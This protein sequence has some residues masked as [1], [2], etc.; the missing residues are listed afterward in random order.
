[1]NGKRLFRY[2]MILASRPREGIRELLGDP[3]GLSY[4]SALLLV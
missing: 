4:A 3:I 2:L 1:M